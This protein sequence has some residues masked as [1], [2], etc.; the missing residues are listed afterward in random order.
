[1]KSK[2]KNN[3]WNNLIKFSGSNNNL[4]SNLYKEKYDYSDVDEHALL[5]KNN[6]ISNILICKIICRTIRKCSKN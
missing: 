1:M 2:D 5:F 6:R 4:K 3:D